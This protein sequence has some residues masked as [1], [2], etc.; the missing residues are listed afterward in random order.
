MKY[1]LYPLAVLLILVSCKSEEVVDA[2]RLVGEFIRVKDNGRVG[3]SQKNAPVITNITFRSKF[4]N[5]TY[6][7]APMSGKYT[8]DEGYVYIE[9]GGDLGTLSLEIITANQLE[10]EGWINGSYMREGFEGEYSHVEGTGNWNGGGANGSGAG[11][12][13][14]NNGSQGSSSSNDSQSSQSPGPANTVQETSNTSGGNSSSGSTT[15]E[16]A[17]EK[18]SIVKN[19]NTSGV[20]A[21]G[22][23]TISYMLTV[24]ALG[25]VINAKLNKSKTTT[26]NE[27]LVNSITTKVKNELKYNKIPGTDYQKIAYTVKL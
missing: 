12:G 15:T 27:I 24:N 4:C 13:G 1:I 16:P 23:A 25:D 10:G 19:I 18:R 22:P 14:G 21:P 17:K 26:N 9:A 6:D 20:H 3:D 8:V 7:G 11:S 5:F 2:E